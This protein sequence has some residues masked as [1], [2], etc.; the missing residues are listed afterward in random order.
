MEVEEIEF[1]NY[2]I[3]G[4]IGIMSE[5]T[6]IKVL[7][8]LCN[9]EYIVTKTKNVITHK[10]ELSDGVDDERGL[11][12]GG[13]FSIHQNV[14]RLCIYKTFLYYIGV[15]PNCDHKEPVLV[16]EL[17]TKKEWEKGWSGI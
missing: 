2:E 9:Q 15:C 4:R 3:T 12:L 8:E 14:E 6:K 13:L 17:E 5:N 10:R 7:C 1:I 16:T 11:G